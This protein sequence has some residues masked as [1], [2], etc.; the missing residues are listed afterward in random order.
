MREQCP[1]VM[2]H[3]IKLD[4]NG[5]MVQQ[6]LVYAWGRVCVCMYVGVCVFVCRR[7]KYPG[8]SGGLHVSA[9]QDR[10]RLAPFGINKAKC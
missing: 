9:G 8:V 10:M 1:K 5:M 6:I 7:W 3:V 2:V 4:D